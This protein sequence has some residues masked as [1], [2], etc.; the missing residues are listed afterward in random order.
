MLLPASLRLATIVAL[1]SLPACADPS[2]ADGDSARPVGGKADEVAADAACLGSVLDHHLGPGGTGQAD[3]GALT[4]PLAQHVLKVSGAACPTTTAEMIALLRR[5]DVAGCQ[6][7]ATAG[8]RTMLVSETAQRLDRPTQYRS[9]TVRECGERPAEHLMWSQLGLT[10]DGPLPADAEIMAFDQVRGMFNFYKLEGGQWAFHGTSVDLLTEGSTSACARCHTTGGPLMKE[11]N[12]PWLHWEGD[13]DTPGAAA[14]IDAHDD[15]GTHS[16]G[17]ELE[18]LVVQGNAEWMEIWMKDLLEAGD[19]APLLRP[20]FCDVEL[21]VGTATR[22]VGDDVRFLPAL[23]LIDDTFDTGSFPLEVKLTHAA[24]EAA[25]A[26]A[27]QRVEHGGQ[28]LLDADGRPFAD[29]IFKI[30]F[31]HRGRLDQAFVTRLEQIG[32]VDHDFVLDVLSVDMTRPIGS[33]ERCALLEF[34]PTLPA[35]VQPAPEAMA[36]AA[37]AEKFVD[38]IGD[39]CEPHQGAGCSG[40]GIEACVCA[41][42][43]FCC[44]EEWDVLC[45]R[46]VT[47]FGCAACPGREEKFASAS[48]DLTPGIASAIRD[49]FIENLIAAEPAPDSAAAELLAKLQD[50]QDSAAHT[51]AAAEFIAACNRREPEPLAADLLRIVSGRRNLARELPMFEFEATLPVDDLA[52]DPRA[53]LDP[54]SCELAP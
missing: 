53:A 49:G 42:D 13:A 54:V 2:A 19:V 38:R 3:L 6:D 22:A 29:T 21:N 1:V 33:A 16:D 31:V 46:Q 18:Q 50:R 8:M 5:T 20:L 4:D 17:A 28:P 41:S 12:N 11:I 40:P 39:C 47:D 7:E 24:Y 30:P 35:L 48:V 32:A 43:D 37:V 44:T 9:V 26:A 36:F 14:L 27:G 45:I 51:T 10:P 23:A 34:A 15:L 52:A 25:T